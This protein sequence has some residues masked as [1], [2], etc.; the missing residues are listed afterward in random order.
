M[1]GR[2]KGATV[3]QLKLPPKLRSVRGDTPAQETMHSKVS[4]TRPT[5]PDDLPTKV[6]A[7]WD[8]LVDE[9]DNAGLLATVDGPAIE[10]ALRHYIAA[11]E[12]S[13]HLIENGP[14]AYDAKNDRDMKNPSSQVF[15][16]HSTAYLEFAKN[17]G[18]TFV[19]RA[20]V[21]MNGGA[22]DDSGNPFSAAQ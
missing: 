3:S 6:D 8:E 18:L 1:A 15:R 16:D 21:P 4:S 11:T 14:T 19:A 7:L 13:N 22:A 10:L 20:R 12:A 17:L 5:K 9:L 2:P